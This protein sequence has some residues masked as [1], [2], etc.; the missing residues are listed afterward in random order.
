MESMSIQNKFLNF[1]IRTKVKSKYFENSGY[2]TLK[3]KDAIVDRVR[4]KTGK[5]P[6][7]DKKNNRG[8]FSQLIFLVSLL[9][10]RFFTNNMEVLRTL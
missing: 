8:F 7:I 10:L 6:N 4:N 2:T 5:R 3:I 9:Y 1:S